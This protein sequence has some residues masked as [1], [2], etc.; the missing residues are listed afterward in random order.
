MLSRICSLSPGAAPCPAATP[1]EQVWGKAVS[2]PR[3]GAGMALV[4]EAGPSLDTHSF[5]PV[6][7]LMDMML[8]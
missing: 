8:L 4:A 1:G 2:G 7:T 6:P 3:V 5:S